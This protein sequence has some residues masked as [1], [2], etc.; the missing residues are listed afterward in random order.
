MNE[1]EPVVNATVNSFRV[2]EAVRD[3]DGAGVSEIAREVDRSK[4]GVYRHVKTLERLGYLTRRDDSYELAIGLWT[5]AADVPERLL[6][7]E[8]WRTLDSVAASNDY[9]VTLLL[10]ETGRAVYAYQECS[11]AVEPLIGGLGDAAPMHAAAAG[12]AILAYLSDDRIEALIEGSELPAM[13]GE[14]ITDADALH[15]A[16]AAVRDRRIAVERGERVAG[17]HSVAAP[18]LV[19]PRRPIGAIAVSATDEELG[20]VDL[21]SEVSS[22]VVNASLAIEKTLS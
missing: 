15:S 21:E 4:G 11:P 19:D 9:S 13:T 14:T 2:L 17:L 20:T 18:I 10:Y 6:T 16:L 12:K 8:G 3:L 7:A 22:F 1:D 5:L